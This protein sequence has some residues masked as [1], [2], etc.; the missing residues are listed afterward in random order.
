[1]YIYIYMFLYI[2]IIYIYIYITYIY[3]YSTHICTCMYAYKMQ[4][5]YFSSNFSVPKNP[6]IQEFLSKYFLHLEKQQNLLA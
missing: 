1:M 4:K 5:V 6:F 2:H 3:I